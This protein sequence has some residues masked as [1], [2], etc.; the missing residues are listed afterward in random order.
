MEWELRS[1]QGE[2]DG[3]FFR[4]EITQ[5]NFDIFQNPWK[6]MGNVRVDCWHRKFS[7]TWNTLGNESK[8]NKF[9]C[10]EETHIL[11]NCE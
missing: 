1:E 2:N 11:Y 9:W 8:L 4:L 10:F 5:S 6:I 7:T 3:N